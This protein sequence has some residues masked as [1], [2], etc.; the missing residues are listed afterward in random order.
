MFRNHPEKGKRI[1]E[2]IPFLQQLI[3][4]CFCHH[5]HWDGS[6]YPQGLRGTEIPLLGR[7]I[8]VGDTYDAMTTDRAY[9]KALPHEA[10]I[11][12]LKRCSGTQFDAEIVVVFIRELERHRTE[13]G[14]AATELASLAALTAQP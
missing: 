7:I 2:P 9:R 14:T 1:L 8:A 13:T 4:G 11:A 10:A 6:G 12:E 3:P 5:E